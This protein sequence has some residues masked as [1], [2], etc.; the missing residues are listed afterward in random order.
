MKYLLMISDIAGRW[1]A[2]S[3]AEQQRTMAGHAALR[4]ALVA[5]KRLVTSF[6]LRPPGEA[7]TVRLVRDGERT[8]TD[9]PFTE[10]KEVMGGAYVIDV[11][12]MDEAIGWAKRIPLAYGS[13]EIR[14]LWE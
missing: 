1:D 8:V 9:G 5:E 14:P 4:E 7:K 12:S 6:R 2:M 3:P 10:T 11:G 13:V